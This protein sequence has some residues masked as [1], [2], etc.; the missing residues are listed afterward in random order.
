M[1]AYIIPA[2]FTLAIVALARLLS[3]TR[4]EQEKER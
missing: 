3:D 1:S 2:A 4:T